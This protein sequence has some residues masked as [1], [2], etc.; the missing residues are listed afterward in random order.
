VF[1]PVLLALPFLLALDEQRHP[2]LPNSDLR[3]AVAGL[4][5]GEPVG[6]LT[7]ETAIPWS[8]TLQG[9]YRYASRYNG[10]WMMGAIIDNE[11]R[12]NADPKLAALGRQIVAETVGDFSCI[13]P[14]RIIVWRPLPGQAAFDI[15][16]F[17]RRDPG[18]V[19][20]LAH[21]R[22]RSRT[23]LET[24]ELMLPVRP[25]RNPCRHGV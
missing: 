2:A 3:G 6:F 21:Y 22:V 8:V 25:G 13:V 5:P 14:K 17:F 1:G 24:Y 10:F 12:G 4:A 18:F 9:H 15:L 19:A 7:T 20:L 23:S 16:P 11:R